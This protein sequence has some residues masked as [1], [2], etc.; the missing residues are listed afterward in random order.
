MNWKLQ[1][2][3]TS[4]KLVGVTLSFRYCYKNCVS[5]RVYYSFCCFPANKMWCFNNY[6]IFCAEFCAVL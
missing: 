2:S 6:N 3:N 4:H 1:I 5:L